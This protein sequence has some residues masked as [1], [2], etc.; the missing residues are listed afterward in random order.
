M[1]T[2]ATF[3]GAWL[4]TV[5]PFDEAQDVDFDLLRRHTRF[6]VE[7]GIDALVP[8]GNT[9]E[10]SSLTSDEVVSIVATIRDIAPDTRLL[11]GV[12]GALP[13]A[14]A[15]TSECMR[16]G[17]TGVMIHHPNHVHTSELGIVEYL[18]TIAFAA[19]GR[20]VVYKRAPNPADKELQQLLNDG[21]LAGVKYAINDL[22][23]FQ[24]LRAGTKRGVLICGTAELWAPF[25]GMCGADG[26]T[27]GLGN[28]FPSL[29]VAMR[30]ALERGDYSKASRVRALAYEFESLRAEDNA[31]KNVPAV[32]SAMA[33]AGFATGRPRLP[34]TPLTPADENRVKAIW[35]SWA[36]ADLSLGSILSSGVA[37][38]V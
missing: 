11:P 17:A 27:S 8:A 10:F 18:K 33:L 5:T 12:G 2:D 37:A 36:D 21:V 19:G 38:P 31:A 7:S 23:A 20:A 4:T 6:L 16:L 29:T 28:A 35:R 34:L 26:F 9:G 13:A 30:D 22:T 24:A 1:V 25:F 15:L 14:L 32:R 3:R